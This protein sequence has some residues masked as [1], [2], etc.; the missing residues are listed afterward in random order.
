MVRQTLAGEAS[1]IVEATANGVASQVRQN[2]PIGPTG[3]LVRGVNVTHFEHGK[4][5]AGAIVKSTAKHAWIFEK[6]TKVRASA[7]GWATGRGSRKGNRAG[8]RGAMPEAPEGQKMIPVVVRARRRMF[9]QLF[10]LLRR[11]GFTVGD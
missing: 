11:N 1:K 2:Y 4:V 3:N 6:G 7:G 8:N 9:E 5:A 10:D